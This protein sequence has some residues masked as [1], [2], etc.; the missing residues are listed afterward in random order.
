MPMIDV[1][2][3]PCYHYNML[4]L[5]QALA[6]RSSAVLAHRGVEEK[7]LR[8][9]YS[10]SDFREHAV[11]FALTDVFETR[12]HYAARTV[13]HRN[14]PPLYEKAAMNTWR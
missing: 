11:G 10:S 14:V 1:L 4:S 6:G 12:D 5:Q 8:I 3:C 2:A 7:R 13:S 9:G